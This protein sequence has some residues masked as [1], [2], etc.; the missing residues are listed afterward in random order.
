MARLRRTIRR[1][2][3]IVGII[4]N[5]LFRIVEYLFSDYFLFFNSTERKVK[6]VCAEGITRE[7]HIRNTEE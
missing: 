4:P 1:I 2:V 7:E 5:Y 3:R 6:V